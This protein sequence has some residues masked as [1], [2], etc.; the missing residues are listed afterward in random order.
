MIN[1][2][3]D[4]NK[5]PNGADQYRDHCTENMPAQFFQV[6]NEGH[7]CT[8]VLIALAQKIKNGHGIAGKDKGEWRS[9]LK[10]QAPDFRG[11]HI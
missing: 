10:E 4:I 8:V 7:F 6:I 11:P 1:N 5:N 9:E 2:R 3:P